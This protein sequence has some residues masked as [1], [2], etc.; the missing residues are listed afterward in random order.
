MHKIQSNPDLIT[1]LQHHNVY[2]QQNIQ[3]QQQLNKQQQ[4]IADLIK[5]V[6]QRR[7][8]LNKPQISQMAELYKTAL[9]N[10]NGILNHRY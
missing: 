6:R 1:F 9:W 2:L 4:A 3:L 7:E 8:D 10:A 5:E